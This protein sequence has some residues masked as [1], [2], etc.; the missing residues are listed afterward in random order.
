MSLRSDTCR[1]IRVVYPQAVV[2]MTYQ[3]VF[4]RTLV[5][6]YDKPS[7]GKYEEVSVEIW[8]SHPQGL[9]KPFYKWLLYTHEGVSFYE[10]EGHE[11]IADAYVDF[12]LKLRRILQERYGQIIDDSWSYIHRRAIS[13]SE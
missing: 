9:E 6:I 7:V 3:T 1:P 12:L 10:S 13:D 8:R 4:R 5:T 2:Q 11:N